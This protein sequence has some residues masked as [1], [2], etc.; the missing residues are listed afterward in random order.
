MRETTSV[1]QSLIDKV[2]LEI[3]LNLLLDLLL[4]EIPPTTVEISRET[5][6]TSLLSN[7]KYFV[8]PKKILPYDD[9]GLLF[10]SFLCTYIRFK[11]IDYIVPFMYVLFTYIVIFIYGACTLCILS[12]SQ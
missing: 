4:S 8:H 7:N 1:S 5:R 3:V 11:R 12:V 10:R 2:R 6:C 9:G